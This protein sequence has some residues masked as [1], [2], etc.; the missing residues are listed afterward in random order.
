VHAVQIGAAGA[1]LVLL[2]YGRPSGSGVLAIA[3]SLAYTLFRTHSIFVAGRLVRRLRLEQRFLRMLSQVEQAAALPP[4]AGSMASRSLVVSGMG[5]VSR[6]RVR[7][8]T[9]GATEEH[10]RQGLAPVLPRL[11]VRESA[12]GLA[13]VALLAW[14][15][16]AP[17][18]GAEATVWPVRLALLAAPIALGAELLGGALALHANRLSTSLHYAL[19]RALVAR[20]PET[21]TDLPA[22]SWVHAPLY[23]ARPW[24]GPGDAV[25][26]DPPRWFRLSARS[27]VPGSAVISAVSRL[28]TL[29]SPAG[30]PRSLDLPARAPLH[31]AGAAFR[32]D[33]SRTVAELEA[34]ADLPPGLEGR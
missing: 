16:G 23:A 5:M 15:L 31:S 28:K 12:A 25:T 9:E 21:R 13:L 7:G 32:A 8:R 27:R 24:S 10:L 1:L 14:L 22:R 17:F 20:A 34:G 33:L 2:A 29:L 26:T 3:V 4:P 18:A 6:A 30:G 19:A 11:A